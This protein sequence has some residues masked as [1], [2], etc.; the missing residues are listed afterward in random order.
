MFLLFLSTPSWLVLGLFC[1][2]FLVV[3]SL[4]VSTSANNSL[5]RLTS[6]VTCVSGGT[7]NSA[8]SL[9]LSGCLLHIQFF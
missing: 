1:V 4:A 6:V 9:L 7:L 5:E 8:R 3:L 2:F